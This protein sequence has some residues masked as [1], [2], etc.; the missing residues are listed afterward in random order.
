MHGEPEYGEYGA[1]YDGDVGAPETPRGAGEDG[2]GC[3][4][5]Y[6][7]CAVEGDD[8]AY[9]E[10]GEGDDGEA[11]APCETWVLLEWYAWWW[12]VDVPIAMMLEANCHVAALWYVRLCCGRIFDIENRT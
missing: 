12:W 3:V 6:A 5:D 1:R 10:E 4:V 7:D 11:F 2:E 8:E 9:C